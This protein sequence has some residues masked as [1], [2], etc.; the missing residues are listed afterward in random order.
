MTIRLLLVLQTILY[1][2]A[3]ATVYNYNETSETTSN[4]L[5]SSTKILL[6]GDYSQFITIYDLQQTTWPQV[7]L[8]SL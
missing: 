4:G 2:T 5:I 6:L 1:Y 3:G 8:N 7:T